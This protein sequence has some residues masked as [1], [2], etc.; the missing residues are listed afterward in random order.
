MSN[1]ANYHKFDSYQ[2][3]LPNNDKSEGI[4]NYKYHFACENNSEINYAT[5]KIWDAII[6][7]TLCFYYGCPNLDHYI[8]PKA[9]IVLNLYNFEESLNIIHNA[10]KNDAWSERIDII[11]Q[12]K[13]KILNELGFLP[14]LKK[15]L[16]V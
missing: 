1:D 6:G 3:P 5:E 7:E 16:N 2:G 9:Y 15:I 11:R 10:I 8:N 12:E 13:Q 14:N 4:F